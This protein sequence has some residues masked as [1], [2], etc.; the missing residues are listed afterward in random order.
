MEG[1]AATPDR[2]IHPERSGW[3][4]PAEWRASDATSAWDL[5]V[6][7]AAVA[8]GRVAASFASSRR[9]R[10]RRIAAR[11]RSLGGDSISAVG[12]SRPLEVMPRAME[13]SQA[14]DGPVRCSRC[15]SLAF[16]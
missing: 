1:Q 14:R 16:A 5:I 11:S 10:S 13:H 9:S 7:A 15:D 12:L 3:A 6:P 2:P 8:V 4:I